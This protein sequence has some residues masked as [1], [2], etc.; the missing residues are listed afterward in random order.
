MRVFRLCSRALVL[1]CLPCVSAVAGIS[2]DSSRLIFSAADQA[3]GQS[4]GVSSSAKSPAPYLVK[5]Q[6]LGDVRGDKT[7]TP[8]SVTPSLFRLEPGG[9]NQL[10]ILKTGNQALAKDKES[11]FYLRVIALPAGQG[12]ELAPK[13][14]V[15]GAVTVSTGSVIKL[16]YRPV[17]LSQTQQQA[18]AG[19]QFTQQGQTL[20]V[21]NPSPYYVTLTSL[22]VGG[23]AVAVSARQQN[24]MI[25]P[26]SQM[27][28]PSTG[29]SG[30]VTWQAINDFGGVEKFNGKIQ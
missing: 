4:I 2:L 9:T 8:F 16:F 10:R 26:F 28:Y 13:T 20:R 23:K 29:T 3:N 5:A 1:L 21:A 15:G 25:A 6:V 27:T 24:T 11:L 7:D 12:S 19:L 22:T 14:E 17:G 30:N 18:M